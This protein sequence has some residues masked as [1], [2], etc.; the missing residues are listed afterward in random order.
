MAVCILGAL[1]ASSCSKDEFFGLEDSEVLDYSAKYEIAMSQAYAD[2]AN[3]RACFSFVEA[4]N[5]PVDTANMQKVDVEGK[6]VY[7]VSGIASQKDN[8]VELLQKIKT[9]FPKLAMADKIDFDEIMDIALSEN[10]ALSDIAAAV[11]PRNT[12]ANNRSYARQ[13]L[14]SADRAYWHYYNDRDLYNSYMEGCNFYSHNTVWGAVQSAIWDL[15]EYSG[16]YGAGGFIWDN[17]NSA[18]SMRTAFGEYW[19]DVARYGTPEPEIDFVILPS[20][21]NLYQGELSDI[22]SG[23]YFTSGRIH[24][25]FD[26]AGNFQMMPF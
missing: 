11:L 2:Y 10:K 8:A 24:Y 6:Q 3:A 9:A 13:W 23:E 18:V 5:Q 16:N 1:A 21:E 15:N 20:V 7:V 26:F 25:A 19:P 12:K 14:N 17:D 4:F 22:Y